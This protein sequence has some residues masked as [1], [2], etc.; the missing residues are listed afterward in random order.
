M[1][2]IDC[3]IVKNDVE[4]GTSD[5][6]Y[7]V[8]SQ[9]DYYD[10]SDDNCDFE[11]SDSNYK[12]DIEK[13]DL[14]EKLQ[15]WWINSEQYFQYATPEQSDQFVDHKKVKRL[16]Q[17]ANTFND[18][19]KTVRMESED[20]YQL[21]EG[22]LHLSTTRYHPKMSSPA[23]LPPVAQT[24]TKTTTII[25]SNDSSSESLPRIVRKLSS[26]SDPVN[27]V[28]KW[29]KLFDNL[30]CGCYELSDQVV[31]DVVGSLVS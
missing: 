15:R 24:K 26:V 7:D 19:R 4:K 29:N 13:M 5:T 9:Y 8:D 30:Q 20:T 18:F 11:E 2:M 25:S 22:S 1:E 21:K 10:D 6:V 3:C 17:R 28:V 16:R 23:T 31:V 14:H 27:A 12:F